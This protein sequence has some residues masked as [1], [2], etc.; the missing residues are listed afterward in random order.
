MNLSLSV[1]L[2]LITLSIGL[3]S[4]RSHDPSWGDLENHAEKYNGEKVS[5]CGWFREGFEICILSSTKVQDYSG[6]GMIWISADDDSC[7]LEKPQEVGGWAVV[8]GTYHRSKNFPHA[9]FG[10]MGGY[11]AEITGAKIVRLEHACN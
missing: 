6:K 11:E 3:V 10:H 2:A 5:V 7:S 1:K 8:T 4:C 9:G